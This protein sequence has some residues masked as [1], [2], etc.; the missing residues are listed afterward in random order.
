M[1]PIVND[2]V[3]WSVGLSL[4]LSLSES[5]KNFWYDRDPF[6]SRTRVGPG[7]DLLHIGTTSGEHFIAFIQHNA[8]I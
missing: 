2:R 6:A 4:G 3:A 8:A 5:D 7:K 1:P